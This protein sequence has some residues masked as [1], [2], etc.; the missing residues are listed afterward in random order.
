MSPR[1]HQVASLWGL[2]KAYADD[3]IVVSVFSM[4]TMLTI[5]HHRGM[6]CMLVLGLRCQ[7]AAPYV[8]PGK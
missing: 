1:H 2:D 7:E 5:W 8:P 4:L 6:C 3:M